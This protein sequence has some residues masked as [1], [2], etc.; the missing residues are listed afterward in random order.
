M[1]EDLPLLQVQTTQFAITGVDMWSHI[2]HTRGKSICN[3]RV[4]SD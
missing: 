4:L 1:Q 3:L 2:E